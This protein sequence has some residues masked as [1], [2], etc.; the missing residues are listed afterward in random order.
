MAL[1]DKLKTA[2]IEDLRQIDILMI[3][4]Y[5]RRNQETLDFF[6]NQGI[7]DDSS[8]E[9]ALEV[10]VFN[11]ARQDYNMM[12]AKGRSYPIYADHVGRPDCLA[13]ALDNGKFSR[14]EIKKIPFDHGDTAE[15]YPQRYG[16]ENLLSVI[17][18][19]L[20]NPK[21][22]PKFEGDYD[23]HPVCSCGN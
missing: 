7:I 19:E 18:E 21:P 20:L 17:R 11:Q 16:K 13:Y 8:I 15:T 4:S 5:A 22:L 3:D 14:K 12:T 23:P 9:G 10:A 6:Y 2:T 1:N